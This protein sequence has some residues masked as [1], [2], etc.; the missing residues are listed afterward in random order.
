MTLPKGLILDQ[1]NIAKVCTRVQFAANACPENSLYGFAR[2]F[3]PLLDKPLK[4]PVYLRS[5]NN[6]LPDLVASLH[7]QIDVDSPARSTPPRAGSATPSTPSPT[8]R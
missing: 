8:C 1:S 7:G 2:A 4:G 6:L 5:S 3:T